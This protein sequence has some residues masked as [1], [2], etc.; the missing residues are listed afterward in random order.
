MP[1]TKTKFKLIG[2]YPITE[3]KCG[4]RA[5]DRVKLLK[6]IVVRDHKNK[7]TGKIHRSGEIWEVLSGSQEPPIVLW[8]RQ[9]DGIRHTWDDDAGFWEWFER[10]DKIAA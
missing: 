1:K 4:A 5:G 7:P 2:E 6:D 10:T 3:Y 9:P 8:L